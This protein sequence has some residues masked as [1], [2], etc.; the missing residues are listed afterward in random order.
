MYQIYKPRMEEWCYTKTVPITRCYINNN[1]NLNPAINPTI[2]DNNNSHIDYFLP[3]PDKEADRTENAKLTK[4]Q[5][6]EFSDIFSEIGCLK[7]MF[8]LM[9]IKGGKSYH[10]SLRCVAYTVQKPF[11]EEFK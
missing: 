3:G 11:K 10:A 6:D 7:G 8:L 2:N 5:H 9:I 4:Q 1:S